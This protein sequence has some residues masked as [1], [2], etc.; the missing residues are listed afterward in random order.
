[1]N[2]TDTT[3][4]T[5]TPYLVVRDADAVFQFVTSALDGTEQTCQRNEDGT[6]SHAELRIGNSLIM[7]GQAGGPW[8][9]RSAALYLWVPDVDATYQRALAA[10]AASAAAPTDKPY[11][12]R[13]AEVE[14]GGVT[15]WIGSPVR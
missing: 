2:I 1:M 13:I 14:M 12:H 15:W 11:G 9:P 8:Q 3:Y 4:P 5:V 6:I 7:V 10:G